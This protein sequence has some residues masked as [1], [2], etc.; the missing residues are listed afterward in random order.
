MERAATVA[1]SLEA[2]QDSSNIAKTQFTTIPTEPISQETGSDGGP[3]RQETMGVLL[4]KLEESQRI[5]RDAEVAQS[6]QEEFDAVEKQKMGQVHQ[7]AQGFTE[8]EWEDIIAR[9][10]VDEELTQKL[11]AEER[12]KYSEVD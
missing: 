4:F 6:L 1:T 9:V 11:Q 8:D 10:E 3:R 12:D 7:A 5:S 2:V